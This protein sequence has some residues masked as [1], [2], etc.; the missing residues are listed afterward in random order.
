[1]HGGQPATSQEA[2]TPAG[3][4]WLLPPELGPQAGWWQGS[5]PGCSQAWWPSLSCPALQASG[6]E[7]GLD[8][9]TP[10]SHIRKLKGAE[11]DPNPAVTSDY[12]AFWTDLG[13]QL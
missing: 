6:P 9:A 8:Q 4:V 2:H 12:G 7:D 10:E 3:A 11:L 13:S 5:H 1:M